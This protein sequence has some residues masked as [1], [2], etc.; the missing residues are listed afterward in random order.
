MKNFSL[1]DN[2]T[3]ILAIIGIGGSIAFLIVLMFFPIPPENKEL[4]YTCTGVYFGTL[5]GGVTGYYFGTSKIRKADDT[6]ETIITKTD[7][8]D[9]SIKDETTK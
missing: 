9:K 7:T 1:K 5:V 2:I 8:T 6:T 3:E 4:I